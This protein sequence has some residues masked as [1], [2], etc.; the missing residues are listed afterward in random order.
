MKRS[1]ILNKMI[2]I[3][4]FFSLFGFSFLCHIKLFF[5]LSAAR[6]QPIFGQGFKCDAAMVGG[7]VNIAADRAE[8]YA[9]RHPTAAGNIPD[10]LNVQIFLF[11]HVF[12]L[13]FRFFRL[14]CRCAGFLLWRKYIIRKCTKQAHREKTRR[15][16]CKITIDV[17]QKGIQKRLSSLE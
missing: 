12:S 17:R 15:K 6:A 9:V 1:P 16:S 7:I 13:R 14:N 11:F 10:L 5:R 3:G 8:I 2:K 4:D